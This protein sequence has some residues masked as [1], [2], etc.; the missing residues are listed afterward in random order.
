M[1]T[2]ITVTIC[3]GLLAAGCASYDPNPEATKL[4][5]AYDS[6]MQR[7]R[8]LTDAIDDCQRRELEFLMGLTDEQL[9]VYQQL[10]SAMPTGTGS[11]VVAWAVSSARELQNVLSEEQSYTLGMLFG[12]KAELQK[13]AQDIINAE[14]ELQRQGE[15]LRQIALIDYQQSQWRRTQNQ[16]MWQDYYQ[17]QQMQQSLIGIQNAITNL[18][19]R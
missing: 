4:R 13:E 11:D 8:N 3:I 14:K 9:K 19:R 17:Q 1:K 12:E 7:A 10:I 2:I 18:N 16:K 5:L 15:T 6:L